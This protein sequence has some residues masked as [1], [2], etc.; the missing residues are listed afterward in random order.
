M[1]ERW[2]LSNGT[3]EDGSQ[4]L[5]LAD[6]AYASKSVRGTRETLLAVNV[7]GTYMMQAQE[8]RDSFLD[9][10]AEFL[11]AHDA[12]HVAGITRMGVSYTFLFY[13]GPPCLYFVRPS[14]RT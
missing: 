4:V 10:M 7:P 6:G 8:G 5:V 9:G 14:N 1:A 11:H 3:L 13:L 12:V 2:V